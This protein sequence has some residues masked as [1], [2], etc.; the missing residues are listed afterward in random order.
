M[1][2]SAR[3][4]AHLVAVILSAIVVTPLGA[5]RLE[6]GIASGLV[7]D[8]A[9][10]GDR[11]SDRGVVLAGDLHVRANRFVS[12][13][14]EGSLERLNRG[15]F[16]NEALCNSGGGFA[17]SARDNIPCTVSQAGRDTNRA[18]AFTFRLRLPLQSLE[19]YL[20][21]GAGQ[22]R[23]SWCTS[24]TLQSINRPHVPFSWCGNEHVAA[25]PLGVGVAYAG[26]L[27]VALTIEVRAEHIVSSWA[28]KWHPS[29][30]LGVRIR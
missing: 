21:V 30:R 20:L 12:A 5:Q 25:L 2:L 29:L 28:G 19:P 10:L 8:R 15:S 18:W 17:L 14:F 16:T 13:G 1:D 4:Q 22:I 3:T 9:N 23:S 11:R 24:G 26:T 6:V 7:L 27:P